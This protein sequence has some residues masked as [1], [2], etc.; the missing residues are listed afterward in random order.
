MANLT[1]VDLFIF[2]YVSLVLA[3][4]QYITTRI[5]M[6]GYM[7]DIVTEAIHNVDD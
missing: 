3:I 2:A 5:F 7:N 4:V 1:Y 6:D